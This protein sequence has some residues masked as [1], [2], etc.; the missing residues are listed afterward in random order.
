MRFGDRPRPERA[1]HGT[2]TFL[3]RAAGGAGGRALQCVADRVEIVGDQRGPV[4]EVT[5][6]DTLTIDDRDLPPPGTRDAV[7]RVEA[8]GVMAAEVRMAMGRYP[9]Q[10]ALPFVPG[11]DLVG[12][13]VEAG[14]PASGSASRR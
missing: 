14:V 13:V 10:P 4:G 6:P 2:Q 3:R 9:G 11:Y 8:A 1:E 12:T 7:V 5:G